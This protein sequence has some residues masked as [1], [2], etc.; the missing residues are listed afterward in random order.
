MSVCGAD[1]RVQILVLQLE[2][3]PVFLDIGCLV[4]FA[5]RVSLIRNLG[6]GCGLLVYL[7]YLHL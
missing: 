2:T 5:L 1:L 6:A 3:P 7:V 4:R